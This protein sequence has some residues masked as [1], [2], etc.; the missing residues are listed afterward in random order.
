MNWTFAGFIVAPL[1]RH[2]TW[3]DVLKKYLSVLSICMLC[4]SPP[5]YW[6]NLEKNLDKIEWS[7]YKSVVQFCSTGFCLVQLLCTAAQVQMVTR[8]NWST[9][10]MVRK[11]INAEKNKGVPEILNRYIHHYRTTYQQAQW[12]FALLEF[13]LVRHSTRIQQHRHH[14]K[15]L[16]DPV[17]DP[18]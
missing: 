18:T 13:E 5:L 14:T 4:I 16:L 6:L 12:T 1:T 15:H 2:F 17:N 8:S 9:W 7:P 11:L 10:Y 3:L